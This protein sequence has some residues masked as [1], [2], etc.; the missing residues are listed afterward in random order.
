V[1]EVLLDQRELV[2][3]VHA[4][5]ERVGDQ[6]R[7]VVWRERDLVLGEERDIPFDVEA[8]FDDGRVFQQRMQRRECCG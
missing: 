3:V 2:V 8:D 4:A 7:I 1:A 6:H 5:I